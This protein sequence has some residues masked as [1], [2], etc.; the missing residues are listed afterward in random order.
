MAF[1]RGVFEK[2][3][4]FVMVFCGHNVVI[5]C[6]IVVVRGTLFGG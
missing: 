5:K 3:G 6:L 2:N 1:L 4:V